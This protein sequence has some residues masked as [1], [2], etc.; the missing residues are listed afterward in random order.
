[1]LNPFKNA[2]LAAAILTAAAATPHPLQAQQQQEAGRPADL[3]LLCNIM[4]V[5]RT[6]DDFALV[7]FPGF[8]VGLSLASLA[9]DPEQAITGSSTDILVSYASKPAEG[10]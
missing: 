4:Y 1:M 6:L 3:Q 5:N 10:L 9:R 2:V 8:F 7:E